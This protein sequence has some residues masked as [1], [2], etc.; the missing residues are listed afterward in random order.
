M[1]QHPNLDTY[2]VHYV[3]ADPYQRSRWDVLFLLPCP[4]NQSST[5]TPSQLTN[6]KSDPRKGGRFQLVQ[7]KPDASGGI[8]DEP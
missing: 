2:F 7:T 1:H 4:L 8:V 6:V 5:N 3:G